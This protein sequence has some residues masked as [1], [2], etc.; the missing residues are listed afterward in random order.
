VACLAAAA[1]APAPLFLGVLIVVLLS[2][3]W[4]LAVSRKLAPAGR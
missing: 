1:L 2:I 3:P 4:T